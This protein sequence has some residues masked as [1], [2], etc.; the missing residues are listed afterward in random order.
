[1][2]VYVTHTCKN[3]ECGR[4]FNDLDL[5]NAHSRPPEWKYCPQ[6]VAV[7]KVNPD[8]PPVRPQIEKM[9]LALKQKRSESL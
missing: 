8:K 1:M 7:G 3:K 6:C 4:A 2:T 5:T 9:H